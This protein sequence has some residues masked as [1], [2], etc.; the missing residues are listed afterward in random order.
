MGCTT[1]AASPGQSTMFHALAPMIAGSGAMGIGVAA[2]SLWPVGMGAIA[3]L[4]A[5]TFIVNANGKT[6]ERVKWNA[7]SFFDKIDLAAFNTR[8]L[9]KV[10]NDWVKLVERVV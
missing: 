8:Q 6:A 10:V 7:P 9:E 5:R 2:W 4:Q 3:Q 1:G